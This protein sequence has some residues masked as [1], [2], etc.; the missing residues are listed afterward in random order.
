MH[1]RGGGSSRHPAWVGARTSPKSPLGGC[2][3]SAGYKGIPELTF[4]IERGEITGVTRDWAGWQSQHADWIASK[5]LIPVAQ[6]GP[7]RAR[8]LPNVPLLTDLSRN[9]EELAVLQLLVLRRHHRPRLH[10]AAGRAPRARDC[11][12]ACVR[13]R[14]ARW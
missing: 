14:H 4:A 3:L 13:R 7:E 11:N 9:A 5:K 8:E 10:D 12:A 6:S 1:P 2:L